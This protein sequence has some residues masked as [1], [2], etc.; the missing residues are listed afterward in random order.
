M[1]GL[2]IEPMKEKDLIEVHAIERLVF[3]QPWSLESFRQEARSILGRYLVARSG[4]RVVG[5]AGMLLVA[6]EGHITTLAVHPDYQRR[7]IGTRMLEEAIA[8]AVKSRIAF[9]TL[10]VR[11]SNEGAQRIYER[12]GFR[13]AGLRKDY[14]TDT[15]E[16]ALIMTSPDLQGPEYQRH[17]QKMRLARSSRETALDEDQTRPAEGGSSGKSD[18]ERPNVR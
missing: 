10:E 11:V 7:G 9:L 3:P 16:D 15:G 18:T 1:R 17:L 12:F 13:G 14:Y 2:V 4:T 6:D 5:Y 8:V